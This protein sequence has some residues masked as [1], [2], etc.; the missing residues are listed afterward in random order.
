MRVN[1][2][3]L[4]LPIL[5][6]LRANPEVGRAGG[7]AAGKRK[8]HSADATRL[9]RREALNLALRPNRAFPFERQDRDGLGCSNM[10]AG[11]VRCHARLSIRGIAAA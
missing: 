1:R 2:S 4:C 6:A 8:R 10:P 3:V 5:P 9:K 7:G 11:P